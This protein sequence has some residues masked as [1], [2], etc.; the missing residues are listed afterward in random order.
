MSRNADRA[1]EQLQRA[2]WATISPEVVNRNAKEPRAPQ[3]SPIVP[4]DAPESAQCY[5][6]RPPKRPK[7]SQVRSQ[8]SPEPPKSIQRSA[9]TPLGR[10]NVAD[11]SHPRSR[12]SL[13]F[14]GVHPPLVDTPKFPCFFPKW[15]RLSGP[16]GFQTNN[17]KPNQ[18]TTPTTPTGFQTY[19]NS[20]KPNQTQPTLTPTGFQTQPTLTPTNPTKPNLP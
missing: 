1:D 17:N 20:N 4:R 5:Q 11:R 16:T 6:A 8:S 12:K 9:E 7:H 3:E 18:T 14:W 15:T 2:K 13:I 19:L 10:P